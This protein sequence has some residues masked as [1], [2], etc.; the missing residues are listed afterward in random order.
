MSVLAREPLTEEKNTDLLR[1]AK[2]GEPGAKDLFFAHNYRLI[3]Y[4]ARKF[5]ESGV[6]LDELIALA[7]YGFLKAFNTFDFAKGVKFAT[8]ASRCM[9]NE[10]LIHLRKHKR[11]Q[12]TVSL[13]APLNID[14]DGKELAVAD[15]YAADDGQYEDYAQRDAIRA[16][17]EDFRRRSDPI[18]CKVIELRFLQEEELT[19]K[20][21]SERLGVSQSYVSRLERRAI[22]ELRKFAKRHHLLE[23]DV[24]MVAPKVDPGLLV[25][26]FENTALSSSQIGQAFNLSLPTV[27]K[28][29]ERYK[30]GTL[31]NVEPNPEA[32]EIL[33][34][35]IDTLTEIQKR[36]LRNKEIRERQKA[37]ETPSEV[38]TYTIPVEKP[39]PP[40]TAEEPEGTVYD[41]VASALH[42]ELKS[43]EE[44]KPRTIQ[45]SMDD[46]DVDNIADF[47][48]LVMLQLQRGKTYHFHVSIEEAR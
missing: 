21:I 24:N 22:K 45:V 2:N 28:W 36:Q 15:V 43:S 4:T 1:R 18:L 38:K 30:A 29:R 26:A 35:Y 10:I 23:G 27:S 32:K 13:D 20:E 3:V 40:Q 7:Q 39:E 34:R 14:A 17:M 9:E 33:D 11:N 42:T 25:Y 46:A 48:E 31:R 16:V 12:S 19:Q 44:H 47:L 5:E 8:Y 6:E 41:E 37:Y